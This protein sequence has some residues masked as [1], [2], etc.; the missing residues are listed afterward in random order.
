VKLQMQEEAAKA[1]DGE[2]EGVEEGIE[3]VEGLE[4]GQVR[5]RNNIQ[6]VRRARHNHIRRV[7][8]SNV[9]K[10]I[11]WGLLGHVAQLILCY[12]SVMLSVRFEY[13]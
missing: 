1:E 11:A 5:R 6:D 12:S 7:C 2:L 9:E 4:D 3:E 8:T 13:K 10:H